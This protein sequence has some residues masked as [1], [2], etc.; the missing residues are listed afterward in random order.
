MT[1]HI[2][3]EKIN[4]QLPTAFLVTVRFAFHSEFHNVA[5]TN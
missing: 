1:D 4:T 2:T 3:R 5:N